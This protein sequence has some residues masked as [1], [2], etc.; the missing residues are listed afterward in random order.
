M[1]DL[2]RV[3]QRAEALGLKVKRSHSDG[4]GHWLY[5]TGEGFTISVFEDGKNH[6]VTPQVQ[7][8]SEETPRE[9][10]VRLVKT[11][12]EAAS[13]FALLLE[14]AEAKSEAA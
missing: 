14:D 3:I 6:I 7:V 8:T 9:L 2:Q 12:H 5:V 4:S 10:G 13:V 1:I 11:S